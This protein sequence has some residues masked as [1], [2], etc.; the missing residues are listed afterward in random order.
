VL[1]QV[2]LSPVIGVLA[3][4]WNRR[5]ILIAADVLVALLTL[6]LAGLF[7]LG[8]QTPW[9]IYFFL[10]LRAVGSGFHTSAWGASVVLLV[11]RRHLARIQGLNQAVAGGMAMLS[12]P[13]GA[14]LVSTLPI[15]AVLLIDVFTALPALVVLFLSRLPQPPRSG[16]PLPSMLQDVRDGLRYVLGWPGLLI[17]LGMAALINA[18]LTPTEALLPLLVTRH[19]GG[20][21]LQLGWLNAATGV[22]VVAGGIILGIWGGFRRRVVTAMIGL[23][24]LGLGNA[25]LGVIPAGSFWLALAATAL[26]GLATPITNGSLGAVIQASV[27]PEMQGRVFALVLSLATA[28]APLGLLLAGPIGDTLGVRI[29]FVIGGVVCSLMGV[30]GLC[31]PA[32]VGIEEGGA[33]P[34]SCGTAEP[35]CRA[36]NP[37]PILE[38]TNKGTSRDSKC[39]EYRNDIS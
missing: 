36:E 6:L 12:A 13:L 38:Q 23:I 2:A 8:W 17:I 22:G 37:E 33:E 34:Q 21:A 19:F 20:G 3:D 14:L 7:G 25:A 1:P 26:A 28:A 10:F 9:Q 16:G 27:A 39:A 4:R 18:L 15:Q 11:P 31:L 5:L 29:W 30:L 35:S 32:V 24:G